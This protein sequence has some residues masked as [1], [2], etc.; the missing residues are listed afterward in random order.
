MTFG[1]EG[2]EGAR[3]HELKDVE[4]ILDVFQSHGHN[5][6]SLSIDQP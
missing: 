1:A 3:V 6:V 4:T 2:T 5:E